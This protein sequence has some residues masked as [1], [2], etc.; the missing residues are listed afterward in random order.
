V[1]AASG[2]A[3]VTSFFERWARHEATLKCL[4]RGLGAPRGDTPVAVRSLQAGPGYA[5]AVAVVGEEMPLL[6]CWTF[7]PP[8]QKSRSTV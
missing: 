1:R 6:R 7:G 8:Q 5:A 3:R 2:A 4:G